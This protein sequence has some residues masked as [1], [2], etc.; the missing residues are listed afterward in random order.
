MFRIVMFTNDNAVLDLKLPGCI[1]LFMLIMHVIN[2][3][4]SQMKHYFHIFA[5]PI[6]GILTACKSIFQ[7]KTEFYLNESFATWMIMMIF[8]GFSSTLPWQKIVFIN[9]LCFMLYLIIIVHYYE[10]H[11]YEDPEKLA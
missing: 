6:V 4:T 7:N 5:I 2:K 11:L 3:N 1:F 8:G 9:V 10:Y